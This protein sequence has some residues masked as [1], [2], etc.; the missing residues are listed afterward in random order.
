[1]HKKTLLG[2][3]RETLRFK[4]IHFSINIP[5]YIYSFYFFFYTIKKEKRTI[6]AMSILLF[7]VSYTSRAGLGS[8]SLLFQLEWCCVRCG[9]RHEGS[10]ATVT[11]FHRELLHLR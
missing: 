11:G 4:I 8:H 3:I 9:I 5:F 10:A 7:S 6:M 1:M 2:C